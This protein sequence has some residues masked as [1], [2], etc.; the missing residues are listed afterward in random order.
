MGAQVVAFVNIENMDAGG[1][2]CVS[3]AALGSAISALVLR[4]TGHKEVAKARN[5]RYQ[6]DC[7]NS[8]EE[9][10]DAYP[11]PPPQPT[12]SARQGGSRRAPSSK[13]KH[14]ASRRKFLSESA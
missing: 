9:H 13:N 7:S 5:R 12:L 3:G 8:D 2:V 6:D 11:P 1:G 14:R 4:C 10:S